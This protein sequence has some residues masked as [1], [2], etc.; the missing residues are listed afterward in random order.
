MIERT[1]ILLS[2]QRALL[3]SVVPCL[4][5]ITASWTKDA[6]KI[7]YYY[8]GQISEE[9]FDILDSSTAEISADFIDYKCDIK[10]LRL[11]APNKIPYLEGTAF[12]RFEK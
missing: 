6:I 2:I 9:D 11:D 7:V 5:C 3:G 8:D 1:K 12:K 4:R 10:I